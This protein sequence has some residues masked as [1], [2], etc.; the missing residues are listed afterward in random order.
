MT[1]VC[2]SHITSAAH[3]RLRMS[4]RQRCASLILPLRL[5]LLS[6][7][8]ILMFLYSYLSSFFFPLYSVCSLF[9]YSFIHLFILLSHIF[10]QISLH[11][12]LSS[13][14]FPLYSVCSLFIYSFIYSSLYIFILISLHSSLSSFFF[15][16]YSVCSLFIYSF[17]HSSLSH[18]RGK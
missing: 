1:E 6:H 16:L 7:I 13:F 17:I 8:V 5:I 3:T 18:E 2:L 11:S 12:S 15:P 9:I 10:I 14:F 4:C